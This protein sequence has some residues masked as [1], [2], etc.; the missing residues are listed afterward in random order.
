M[1]GLKVENLDLGVPNIKWKFKRDKVGK[2]V[3]QPIH[4]KVVHPS[5]EQMMTII[6]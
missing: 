4:T 1:K 6:T 3:D 2:Q 5:G